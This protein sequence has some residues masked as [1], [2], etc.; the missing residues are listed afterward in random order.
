MFL[1]P[2]Q[3]HFLLQEPSKHQRI[4]AVFEHEDDTYDFGLTDEPDE[5][6]STS[7]YNSA[8]SYATK[9]VRA[10]RNKFIGG[11]HVCMAA[12]LQVRSPCSVLTDRTYSVQPALF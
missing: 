4:L 7:F 11:E 3:V 2:L 1:L 9:M 6:V 5:D 8:V 12:T 10:W